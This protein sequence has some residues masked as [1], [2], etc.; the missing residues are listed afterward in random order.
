M[1]RVFTGAVIAIACLTSPALSAEP[2]GTWVTPEGKSRVQIANCG[3]ALCGKIIA[4]KEPNTPDGKP[5]LDA[6]NQN[7]G[8]RSRPL[9]GLSLLS[10]MKPSGE[11]WKG[12]IYNPEDGKTYKATMQMTGTSKLEVSGCVASIFCKTQ[13]WTRAQ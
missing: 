12:S 5:K 9:V 1:M 7:E 6:K 2:T 11:S 4:L 10:G 3:D 13:V 8:Q